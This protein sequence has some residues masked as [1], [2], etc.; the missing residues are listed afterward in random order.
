MTAI[1]YDVRF[2]CGSVTVETDMELVED[3][4]VPETTIS[5]ISAAY[6]NELPPYS[7]TVQDVSVVFQAFVNDSTGSHNI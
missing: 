6:N 1:I 2:F 4:D 5:F 7:G 3:V